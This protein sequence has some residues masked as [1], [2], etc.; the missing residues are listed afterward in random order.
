MSRVQKTRVG[1][2]GLGLVLPPDLCASV[3]GEVFRR[4]SLPLDGRG[5]SRTERARDDEENVVSELAER[6]RERAITAF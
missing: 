2:G 6:T 3:Q 5:T 1:G 4:C